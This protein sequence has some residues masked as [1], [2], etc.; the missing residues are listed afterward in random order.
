MITTAADDTVN[1]PLV[2]INTP[3]NSTFE[4]TDCM[5]Q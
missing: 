2:A 5:F 3:T 4:I 1:P